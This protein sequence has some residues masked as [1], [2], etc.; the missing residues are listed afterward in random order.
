MEP[1]KIRQWGGIVTEGK[2]LKG[3][4][5]MK[6]FQHFLIFCSSEDMFLATIRKLFNRD[7]FVEKKNT[8]KSL[9]RFV[10]QGRIETMNRYFK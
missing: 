10:I 4:G 7:F 9:K 2:R 6:P 3:S 8:L 5:F 1:E